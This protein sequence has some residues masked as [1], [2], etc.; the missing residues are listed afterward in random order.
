MFTLPTNRWICICVYSLPCFHT[1]HSTWSVTSAI[2]PRA[3]TNILAMSVSLFFCCSKNWSRKP[4]QSPHFCQARVFLSVKIHG[5]FCQYTSC[6]DCWSAALP[7]SLLDFCTSGTWLVLCTACAGH[8]RLLA[9]FLG[10]WPLSS[11]FRWPVPLPLSD[12]R[13]L[14]EQPHLYFLL[15]PLLFCA[16]LCI[17]VLTGQTLCSKSPSVFRRSVISGVF[18]GV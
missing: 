5:D 12:C 16:S 7:L 6:N 9:I 14:H 18:P 10:S 17:V 15:C 1:E 3:L 2:L 11:L 4:F 13:L 8:W